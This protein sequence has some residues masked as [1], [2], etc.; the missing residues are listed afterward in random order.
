MRDSHDTIRDQANTIHRQAYE[1]SVFMRAAQGDRERLA[2]KDAEI[3]ALREA[4][5]IGTCAIRANLT[6]ASRKDEV[7]LLDALTRMNKE[8]EAGR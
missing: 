1:I 2:A 4:V 7:I 8:L 6:H 5:T 3:A